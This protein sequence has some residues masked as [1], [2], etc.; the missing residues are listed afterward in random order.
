MLRE[1]L[2]AKLD[3]SFYSLSGITICQLDLQLPIFSHL[4]IVETPTQPQIILNITLVGLDTKMTLQ[5]P[6]HP[7]PPTETQC[8]L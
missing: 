8:P 6:P 3:H 2:D 7:T 5:V 4:F 1:V